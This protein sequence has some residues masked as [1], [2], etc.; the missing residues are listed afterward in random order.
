MYLENTIIGAIII[1]ICIVPFIIMSKNRKKRERKSL[2]ALISTA[3]KH[4][5]NISMHEI[6]GDF[7]IGIDE[8]HKNVFFVKQ[9]KDNLIEQ[10]V[11]LADIQ[12]CRIKN[13]ARTISDKNGNFNVVDK[14]ELSFVPLLKNNKEI[15]LEFYNADNGMLIVGELQSVEKW[16]KLINNSMQ[17][18]K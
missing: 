3:S 10:H 15:S 8:P 11:N 5:C 1:A 12:N 7:I 17:T 2:Q 9:M 18:K 13:T 6:C 16:A 14:L 4:N